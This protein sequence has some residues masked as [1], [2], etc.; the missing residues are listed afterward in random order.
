[1]EETIFKTF[2]KNK[3]GSKE[4]TWEEYTREGG[5][6]RRYKVSSNGKKEKLESWAEH[7]CPDWLKEHFE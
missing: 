1:M 7:E 4:S 6:I 2:K 5:N 3:R